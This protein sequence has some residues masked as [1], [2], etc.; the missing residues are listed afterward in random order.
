VGVRFGA[1]F[2]AVAAGGLEIAGAVLGLGILQRG[3]LFGPG[4]FGSTATG[5]GFG[6]ACALTTIV[7]GVL[8]MYR[9]ETRFLA[10]MVALAAGLGTLAAGPAFGLAALVALVA[11]TL[12][13]RIDPAAPLS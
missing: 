2:L 12:A 4:G 6:L 10:G 8:L 5:V 9:R 7:C 1:F 13:W 11:A 3:F